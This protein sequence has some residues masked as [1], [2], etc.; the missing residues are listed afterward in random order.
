MHQLLFVSLIVDFFFLEPR[1]QYNGG[2]GLTWEGWSRSHS[3][4]AALN[5]R[6]KVCQLQTKLQKDAQRSSSW[7]PVQVVHMTASVLS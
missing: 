4:S 6:T 5:S 7:S 1:G 2:W 3:S